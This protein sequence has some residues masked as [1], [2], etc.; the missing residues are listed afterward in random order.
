MTIS[1]YSFSSSVTLVLFSIERGSTPTLWRCGARRRIRWLVFF[2]LK[3]HA[4]MRSCQA[5]QDDSDWLALTPKIQAMYTYRFFTHEELVFSLH[6][7]FRDD[8]TRQC[9]LHQQGNNDH[10]FSHVAAAKI[11][12][13]HTPKPCR[14]VSR[15]ASKQASPSL[16]PHGTASFSLSQASIFHPYA[17]QTP[18]RVLFPGIWDESIYLPGPV[19]QQGLVLPGV[20]G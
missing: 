5:S 17:R 13:A 18:C 8:F 16:Q 3:P 14:A 1:F 19:N 4:C 9:L 15:G 2:C 6:S 20:G 11:S 7:S 10:L 12:I